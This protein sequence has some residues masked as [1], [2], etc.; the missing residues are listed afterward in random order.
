M[1]I[2]YNLVEYF[3]NNKL[4]YVVHILKSM[5]RKFIINFPMFK[6][7]MIMKSVKIIFNKI[8]RSWQS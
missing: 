1:N 7:V 2:K 4:T 8:R 6:V 5:M 3:N